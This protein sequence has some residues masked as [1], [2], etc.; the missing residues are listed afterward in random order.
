MNLFKVYCFFIVCLFIINKIGAQVQETGL[1]GI[2]NYKRYDYNGA[3]QNWNIDQ[4]KNENLYFANNAGLFQF[5]GSSWNKFD[6]TN[7]SAVRSLRVGDSDRIYVGGH[8]EFGF[9]KPDEKGKLAYH[10][11]LPLLNE[12][13]RKSIDFIWKIHLFNN[14]VIFQSFTQAYIYDGKKIRYLEAPNRFQFSFI[15]KG[16]LYFQDISAGLFEYKNNVLVPLPGTEMLNAAEV[17]GIFPLSGNRLLIT[18]LNKGAF[19][20]TLNGLTPWNTDAGNFIKREGSL[21]GVSIKDNYIV[22]NSV[23]DG[24][25][26]SDTSGKIVQHL[27]EK[28]GLQ[29]NTILSSFVDNKNNLWLA[30]DN[31][32]DFINE[33]SPITYFGSSYN[34]STV[35]A[36]ILYKQNLYV[37]TN[38]GLF[39]QPLGK[40]IN[41]DQFT[42]VEGTTGQA[43]NI[44]EIDSQ[45]FCAS[46]RGLLLISGPRAIKI[47]DANGYW[48]IKKIPG[49]PNLFMGSLYNGFSIFEKKNGQWVFRNNIE[50]DGTSGNAF[51]IGGADVW[52]LKDSLLYQMKLNNNFSRFKLTKTYRNLSDT[53]KGVSGV[54]LLNNKIYF[55]SGNHFYNYWTELG[56]FRE[57]KKIN[58]LFKDV[59]PIRFLQQDA[60]GNIWY[61]YNE[62]FGMLKKTG[63]GN[64]LNVAAPFAGLK[65]NL[66]YD[67][68]SVNVVDTQNVF[69][70]LT[71]GLGHF[72]PMLISNRLAK[73]R[74]YIRSFSFPGDTLIFGNS[75]HTLIE[76]PAIPYQSN[77]VKFTFSSPMYESLENIEFSYKLEGFDNAWSDWTRLN[78]KEYTN[79]HEG[80]Y[81][82]Y[83]RARNSFGALS[84]PAVVSFD[85]SPPFYR[86]AA[87]YLL[88]LSILIICIILLQLRIKMKIR[89]HKYYETIEQ[90][91][92]YLEK[93]ARI[94]LEQDELEKEIK[95]L[96]IEKLQISLLAKDKELVNNS[97]QV[98]KKN[99][100]LNGIIQKIKNID[101]ETV[102]EPTKG[103][104][105]KLTKSI[106]KD[107]E[108]DNGWNNL[109]RHIKNVHFD[110]L[111]RLKEKYPDISPRELDLACYLLMNMSSKEI[112]EIMN[113]SNESV[114]LARYR[115]R[116]KMGLGRND[117]LIGFLMSI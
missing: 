47:L 32:I 14:E 25:I 49:Q 50:G 72:N 54:Y 15:V 57:D 51:E 27:D 88:Y 87:A 67:Y 77:N 58:G 81:K 99:K 107:L 30:L 97:F 83:V 33:S 36:S 45:L 82:M 68:L 2:K 71:N 70:G 92:L 112:A 35:Y 11:L 6:L 28:N 78:I 56:M 117:N 103:K 85:V 12:S 59:P 22:F 44:Q 75:Q 116:K 84:E 89:K 48:C 16:R 46:N 79:L 24:A 13:S 17:W 115:L 62:S 113:I 52:L 65:G 7:H 100:M 95:Q 42:L 20:Y 114:E 64:Y 38:Q 90:R 91:K 29:N 21:G 104:L 102:E 96:K 43:W 60:N 66:V 9:F 40:S 74:V 1:P 18:T 94:K 69:I 26:I 80:G 61:V 39:Y 10:S 111:K 93:E 37:A 55:Q 53:V 5:D 76:K 109:E 34:I 31:G 86:H 98:V 4:D 41:K 63:N 101:D 110:F 108:S 105:H 19:I 73:P 3:T 23:L 8:D 106:I